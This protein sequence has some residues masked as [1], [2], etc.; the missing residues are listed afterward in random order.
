MLG[1][2]QRHR[3]RRDDP[4]GEHSED[5]EEEEELPCLVR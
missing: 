3:V 1:E 5:E 4:R 2:R